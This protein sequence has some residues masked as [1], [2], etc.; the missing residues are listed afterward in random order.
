MQLAM[1]R[2]K[3]GDRMALLLLDLDNFKVVNDTMGHSAGDELLQVV[4][5]RLRGALRE[6]DT[7][8]R[9][10]GDEFAVLV[11]ELDHPSSAT[12]LAQRLISILN[13]PIRIGSKHVICGGSIGIAMAPDDTCDPN[14]LFRLADLALYAA[15]EDQRGTFRHFESEL[16]AKVKARNL[17]EVE[18]REAISNNDFELHYQPIVNVKTMVPVGAEALLRWKHPRLGLASPADFIPIAEEIGMITDLGAKVLRQACREAMTWPDHTSVSVNVSAI[19]LEAPGFVDTVKAA[20]AES[21]LPSRRLT[22]EV[23]ESMIM[24]DVQLARHVLRQI[25]D[26]GAEI[27]MDDF[28]TGYS[29]LSSLTKVPFQKIKIDRSFVRDLAVSME[30]RAILATIVDLARTLGMRTTAEGVETSEQLDIVREYGCTLVQGFLFH[31]PEPADMV[32]KILRATR[33]VRRNAA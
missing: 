11:V 26:L 2:A 22:I 6:T 20:L 21:G 7:V 29:S 16:D 28:G 14:E 3:R 19:E 31:R 5:D 10:G 25:C 8:A 30:A 12:R 15:K 33:D 18:V 24:K 32:R 27:A 23:T 9:L 1:A 17:L 4:A 13:E